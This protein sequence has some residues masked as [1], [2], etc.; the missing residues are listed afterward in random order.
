[1]VTIVCFLFVLLNLANLDPS[2]GSGKLYQLW[3]REALTPSPHQVSRTGGK[4]SV[5]GFWGPMEPSPGG[6]V[7]KLRGAP[8]KH[9]DS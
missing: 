7:K 9:S 5:A 6:Q 3:A 8:W 2:K 4:L 1:M